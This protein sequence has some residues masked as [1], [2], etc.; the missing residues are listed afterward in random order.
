M[1]K[2]SRKVNDILD[3]LGAK[4]DTSQCNNN[5]Y[6]MFAKKLDVISKFVSVDDGIKKL[7]SV[8]KTYKEACSNLPPKVQD[9]EIKEEELQEAFKKCT[10]L[11]DIENKF[12]EF[13]YSIEEEN[14]KYTFKSE[15]AEEDLIYT[16]E[17]I[18]PEKNANLESRV[19]CGP[20]SAECL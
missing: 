5:G 18:F 2:L 3:K 19:Q 12:Q 16:I 8:V 4:V 10:S 14:M 6:E 15:Y 20:R 1:K 11:K 17:E 13:R 9:P 7:D